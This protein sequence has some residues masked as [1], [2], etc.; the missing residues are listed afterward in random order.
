M[1]KTQRK[2][3]RVSLPLTTEQV[4]ELFL[5]L[6]N[7]YVVDLEDSTLKGESLITYLANM[8]IK[9][10][11]DL[12]SSIPTEE[13]IELLYH[14]LSYRQTVFCETLLETIGY[15]LLRSRGISFEQAH[16]W[17]SLAEMDLFIKTHPEII[18]RTSEFLDSALLFVPSFDV[19]FKKYILEPSIEAGIIEDIQDPTYIGVN[20]YGLFYAHNFLE[21]FIAD[22]P[23]EH[24]I[25]LKYFRSQVED[26]Q[27][28]RQ[29]LFQIFLS[30][31]E[32]S[33]LMSLCHVL[34]STNPETKPLFDR[35]LNDF[36]SPEQIEGK[37]ISDT[38][39]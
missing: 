2:P 31:M 30:R 12:S 10:T 6:D 35:Y 27:Y 22:A 3:I 7:R 15:V 24:I 32:N 25:N 39:L 26:I 29:H 19:N 1:F 4:Q 13:K 9:C 8:Q 18:K 28:N 5:N 21:F 37:E 23:D 20:C 16:E 36:K 34:F 17:M 11:L 14:F 38:H 33:V